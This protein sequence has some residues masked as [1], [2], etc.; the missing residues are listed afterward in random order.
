MIKIH[1]SQVTIY[2][3]YI[4][5]FYIQFPRIYK[6]IFSKEFKSVTDTRNSRFQVQH[7]LSK[8]LNG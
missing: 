2:I 8:I 5:L 4:Q 1:R 7:I 6:C 3:L